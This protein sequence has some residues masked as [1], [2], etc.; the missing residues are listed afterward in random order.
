MADNPLTLRHNFA[1]T[2]FG[3]VFYAASSWL[4]LTA[5]AKLGSA[6]MLGVF[7]LGLAVSQPII[8]FTQLNLSSIITTDVRHTFSY[9]D[10]FGLRLL[11][12]L[13]AIA[14]TVAVCLGSGYSRATAF[15]IL[16]TGIGVTFDA[17]SDIVYGHFRRLERMDMIGISQSIKG[18]LSLAGVVL[19]IRLAHSVVW[20]A[21]GSA[22]ASLIVVTCYD[23][24]R[25]V[26]ALRES[27]ERDA[28]VT[29]GPFSFPRAGWHL[30]ALRKLFVTA[31][32]MGITMMLVGLVGNVPRYAVEHFAG[33]RELGIFSALASFVAVGRVVVLA[34]GGSATPRLARYIDAGDGASFARLTWKLVG[35]G[36]FVGSLAPVTAAVIGHPLL[37]LFFKPEYAAHVDILVLL[38]AGGGV[39][40]VA[41]FLGCAMTAAR[42]YR[43]Q[44][45]FMAIV[46]V[47]AGVAAWWLTPRYGLAGAAIST[48]IAMAIQLAGAG[49]IVRAIVRSVSPARVSG[50]Q[51][52]MPVL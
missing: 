15:V 36:I 33:D 46:T 20:A 37:K 49:L 10:Y 12:N 31:L 28:V 11:T 43:V 34:L 47:A 52:S 29:F 38:L 42:W 23:I 32:P 22:L 18:P 19:G 25:C 1:W 14:I 39:G 16:I 7:S 35:L 9:G 45:V 51:T 5:I 40:Y 48:I 26:R 4:M 17:V 24:P 2:T 41:M 13:L 6:S 50:E 8:Y 3:N 30:P 44:P 21:T 27:G